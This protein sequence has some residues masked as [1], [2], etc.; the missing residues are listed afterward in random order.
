MDDLFTG[1]GQEV[2]M[3]TRGLPYPRA[4]DGGA[5]GIP[6]PGQG[7]GLWES[8]GKRGMDGPGQGEGLWESQGKRGMEKRLPCKEQ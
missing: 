5:V 3:P 8:Q 1:C 7:E 2:Q 6:W 4:T